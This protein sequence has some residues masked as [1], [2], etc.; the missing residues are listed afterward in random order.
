MEALIG[1]EGDIHFG[2]RRLAMAMRKFS[3]QEW[4]ETRFD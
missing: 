1:T 4:P 2:Q 3:D